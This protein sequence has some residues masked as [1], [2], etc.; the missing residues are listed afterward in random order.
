MMSDKLEQLKKLQNINIKSLRGM[1][2]ILKPIEA[3]EAA[4]VRLLLAQ[5]LQNE[6]DSKTIIKSLLKDNQPKKE[7]VDW[8]SITEDIE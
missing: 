4:A 2:K 8:E 5:L 1:I 3:D 6:L 7:I